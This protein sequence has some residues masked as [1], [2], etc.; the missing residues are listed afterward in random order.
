[1]RRLRLSLLL[2]LALVVF[3]TSQARDASAEV[4]AMTFNI[5][6]GSANDGKDAWP[7][8]R[9]MVLER[10][11]VYN[12][13]LLGLQEALQTQLDFVTAAF[14]QYSMIG[15]GREVKGDGEYSPLLYRHDRFDLIAAGTFW[16]SDTP[17]KPGSATWGNHNPRLCT[18]ARLFDRQTG[19][20]ISVYNTH[21]DH[22][23]QPA[24][25]KGS[26]L[27]ADHVAS[28]KAD[29]I[30]VMGDFNS[31]EE[32]P[33]LV[34]LT[35]VGLRDSFRDLHPE[36]TDVGTFNGFGK[37]MGKSKIDTVFISK[38]WSVQ[39]AAIDRTEQDGRFPSDHFPV[40]ATLEYRAQ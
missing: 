4:K 11:R 34:P 30:V 13:D 5:R 8:R 39:E 36:S 15:T 40:T 29:P 1:M 27:I 21:W 14:P 26:Q 9:E 6:F 20:R 37:H 22:Q 32:N 23:S 35:S 16:L 19:E 38:Q 2:C 24:R 28:H 3:H 10:V 7:H 18:W 31:G 12:P 17:E 33:A 25:E